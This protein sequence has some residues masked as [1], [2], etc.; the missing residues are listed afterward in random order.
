MRPSKDHNSQVWLNSDQQFQ[1]EDLKRNNN[2]RPW[3][4]HEG[5]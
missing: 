1:G 2:N 5:L 3:I 4:P